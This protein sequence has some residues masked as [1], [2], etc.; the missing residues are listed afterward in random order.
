MISD[1]APIIFLGQNI[2]E[3]VPTLKRVGDALLVVSQHLR[4][5]WTDSS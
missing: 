2:E 1:N 4:K 3:V 5:R